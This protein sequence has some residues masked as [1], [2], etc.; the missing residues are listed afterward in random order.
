MNDVLVREEVGGTVVTGRKE[1][2]CGGTEGSQC[3]KDLW[4]RIVC[5]CETIVEFTCRLVTFPKD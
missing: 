4:V 2:R 5:G 1:G 3:P